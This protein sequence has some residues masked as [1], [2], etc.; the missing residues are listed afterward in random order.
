MGP[1]QST[2]AWCLPR[3]GNR[4]DVLETPAIENVPAWSDPPCLTQEWALFPVREPGRVLLHLLDMAA[5]QV[6]ARISLEGEMQTVGARFQG[7]RL[8]VFDGCGRVLAISL[9]SGA[10]VREYRL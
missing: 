3:N 9:I 5:L 1:P 2:K 7:D 8:I 6:R 4:K 10:V